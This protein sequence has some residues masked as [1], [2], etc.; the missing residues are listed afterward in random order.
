MQSFTFLALYKF[1][2]LSWNLF[3][4]IRIFYPGKKPAAMWHFFGYIIHVYI[5]E[6]NS[7]RTTSTLARRRDVGTPEIEAARSLLG[8]LSA[9]GRDNNT[10]NFESHVFID[11]HRSAGIARG[12]WRNY[13]IDSGPAIA[14]DARRLRR[15]S[16]RIPRLSYDRSIGD[17]RARRNARIPDENAP[18]LT[19]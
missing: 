2:I 3:Y 15:S 18:V 14:L 5:S 17:A 16:L 9:A 10:L 12:S 4:F 13:A 6:E 11:N 19:Q 7:L 1:P 8:S